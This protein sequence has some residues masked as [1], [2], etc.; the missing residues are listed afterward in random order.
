MS[1]SHDD[2]NNDDDN[3]QLRHHQH[4]DVCPLCRGVT[5]VIVN[6]LVSQL[7]SLGYQVSLKRWDAN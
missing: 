2:N 5:D 4:D 6:N 1:V 3:I 7:E